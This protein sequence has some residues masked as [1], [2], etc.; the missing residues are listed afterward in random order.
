MQGRS[1]SQTAPLCISC[2]GRSPSWDWLTDLSRGPCSPRIALTTPPAPRWQRLVRLA[3][4]ILLLASGV[5]V[6][7]TVSQRLERVVIEVR[8]EK[9]SAD[10][11]LPTEYRPTAQATRAFKGVMS[12]NGPKTPE[13]SEASTASS[14]PAVAK[15]TPIPVNP[16]RQPRHGCGLVPWRMLSSI[17]LPAR[18]RSLSIRA[19]RHRCPL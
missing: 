11:H 7:S 3:N 6:D 1:P 2:C 19:Q 15:Y 13:A 4:P 8:R 9:P 5:N 16:T 14:T 18:Y 10:W 17:D 12:Q